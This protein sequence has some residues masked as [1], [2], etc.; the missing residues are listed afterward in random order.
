MSKRTPE[1][2]K[3]FFKRN[4]KNRGEGRE[5]Y[6]TPYDLIDAIVNSLLKEKPFLKDKIWVD[7]CAGDGRWAEVIKKYGIKYSVYLRWW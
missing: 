4:T 2:S 5:L 6:Q 1:Q 7:S 3:S